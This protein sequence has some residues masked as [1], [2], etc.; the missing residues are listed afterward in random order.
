[1]NFYQLVT[2]GWG[3]KAAHIKTV[4]NEL[5][6]VTLRAIAPEIE[7]CD[8]SISSNSQQFCAGV[9][10]GIKGKLGVTTKKT[11]IFSI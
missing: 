1:L 6:Q 11:T 5:Q 7:S 9:D 3:L 8:R 2:I 10:T 4:S